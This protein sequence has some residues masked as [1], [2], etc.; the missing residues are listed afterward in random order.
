MI[1]SE[2]CIRCEKEFED[3]DHILG[4]FDQAAIV[5][6]VNIAV[7]SILFEKSSIL[8]GKTRECKLLRG[9]YNNGFNKIT[10]DKEE[11]KMIFR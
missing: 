8:L 6:N 7:T 9:V 3:W 4:D 2:I 1:D 5:R 10:N 11:K